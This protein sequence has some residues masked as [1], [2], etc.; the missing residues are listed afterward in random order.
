MLSE[1]FIK[2]L[3]IV[4]SLALELGP[5]MTALTGETGAGKSIL[6]DALGLA[7]GDK[8]DAGM[9]R[10]GV[11][12]AE[13]T[14]RFDL[15]RL[16]G[17]VDW[18][19]QH[20]LDDG[21]ECILRRVL[22]RE[23]RSR[24][25]ING[26]PSNQ[27]T[28]AE[29][30]QQLVHIHGQQAH[31]ALLRGG[32]QRQLLD[33]YGGHQSLLESVA[34]GHVTLRQAQQE[35]AQLRDSARDQAERQEYL[36]FQLRDLDEL[37]LA[38]DEVSAL[39]TEHGRLAHADRLKGDTARL[40][41]LLEG[42]EAAAQPLLSRAV[43]LLDELLSLDPDL[44]ETRDLL[45]SARIQMEE[46]ASQARHY[47]DGVELDPARLQQIDERLGQAHALARRHRLR[48]EELPAHH[49]ALQEELDALGDL[50]Q[51]E[52]QCLQRLEAATAIYR[53]AALAL[54]KARAKAARRLA[55]SVTASMQ[56]LGMQGGR[57]SVE[58][59]EL[60]ADKG[61]PQGL[62][63]VTF[64]VAANPGQTP[65]P[66]AKVA[67]GGELSRISLAIQVA[68]ADCGETPSLIFDEVD[69]GIG[70]AVAEIVG[71]LLRELAAKRQVFCVTH[72]PQVASQAHQ[73]LQVSKHSDGRQTE[74]AIIPLD[75]QGRI[76]E[77]ARMLG[78]VDITEQTLAHAGE[79]I[80]RVRSA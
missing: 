36:R 57:F 65:A 38:E 68:T 78:G 6:I 59:G 15:A 39:E 50:D 58:L 32:A 42:D 1:I 53:K 40:A 56:Q 66:L 4:R 47:T 19:R 46:A 28:L 17:V 74:T 41:D 37:A 29:L 80:E 24:A 63:Q 5:G 62:D 75:E 79:M 72:L 71:Q 22:V 3:V 61:G 25:F 8:A 18:L 67:S 16:P 48:P 69:V 7:L 27:Q 73:H 43:G 55:E 77:I 76:A 23:G 33:A 11:D 20:D 12:K 51:A 64:M 14:A 9:I 26:T 13:V 54:R 44:Q 60:T 35:L 21:D 45:D 34:A 49:R 2:D 70:G 30:G 52:A 31:Q 10:E